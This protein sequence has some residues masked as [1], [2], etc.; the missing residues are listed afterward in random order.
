LP[1]GK[2]RWEQ[3]L[4][5]EPWFP[6]E[7]KLQLALLEYRLGDGPWKTAQ[8]RDIPVLVHT[9]LSPESQPSPPP[10]IE[11]L[12]RPE[13]DPTWLLIAEVGAGLALLF[14]LVWWFLWRRRALPLYVPPEQTAMQELSRLQEDLPALHRDSSQ[15][16]TRLANVVR[17]YLEARFQVPAP[18]QTSE[19]YWKALT[20]SNILSAE[21]LDLLGDFLRRCELPKFAPIQPSWD[22]CLAT[23]MLARAFIE[24]EREIEATNGSGKSGK[25]RDFSAKAQEAGTFQSK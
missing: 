12:P 11:E 19:E 5:L 23:L 15:F 17:T 1:D 3:V 8:W 7:Q 13:A 10:E 18:R 4:H 25:L 20:Q 14:V 21:Q 24:K 6:K 2:K 22:E 16:H 9:T